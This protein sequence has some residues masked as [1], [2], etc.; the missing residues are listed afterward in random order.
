VAVSSVNGGSGGLSMV[1]LPGGGSF[2]SKDYGHGFAGASRQSCKF[3]F[4]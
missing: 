4:R 3:A 1:N 2:G